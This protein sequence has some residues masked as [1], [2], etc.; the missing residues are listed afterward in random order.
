MAR[1]GGAVRS[2]RPEGLETARWSNFRIPDSYPRNERPVGPGMA[3][4]MSGLDLFGRSGVGAPRGG[5]TDETQLAGA[6]PSTAFSD[7][8]I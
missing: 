8:A 6:Y 3:V 4:R 7:R 1:Q 2:L 5:I